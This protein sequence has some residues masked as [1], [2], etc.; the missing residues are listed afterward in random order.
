MRD[1]DEKF[2]LARANKRAATTWLYL[3]IIASVFYGAKVIANDV[4]FSFFLILEYLYTPI[5]IL[6]N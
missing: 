4:K 5:G 3:M 6:N 1:Y 2:F